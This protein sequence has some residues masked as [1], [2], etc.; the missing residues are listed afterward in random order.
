M[1]KSILLLSA[2]LAG[3]AFAAR[4]IARWDVVPYQRISGTFKAGVVAFHEKSVQVEFSVNGKK[5]YT[6][7]RPTL[8]TRTKVWEYVFAFDATKCRDG[9]VKIGATA[10]VDGE[11]PYQL[12]DLEMYANSKKTQGSRKC[13]WVDPKDGNEFAE[14]TKDAPVKSLKQAVAKAGDGG[15]VFL[16]PG[17]YQ[18]KMIGGGKDNKYWTLLMP[19]KGVKRSQVKI[20]GGRTGTD[21]LHFKNVEFFSEQ[22]DGYG[23]IIMGEGGETMGWFDNC[24]FYNKA[25]R[26]AGSVSVFG[27]KMRAFVTGGST[28]EVANGPQCELVRG[29][30]ISSVACDALPFDNTLVVN[31]TVSD[32]D[33]T[34]T[35]GDP[36]LFNGFAPGKSWVGDVILYNV[37]ATDVK[38]KGLSGRR[39]R[40]SAFVNVS[41]ESTGGT[42]VYSRFCEEIENC[43]FMQVS[44]VDQAVQLMKTKNGSI[45]FLPTDVRFYN[46]VMKGIDGF[47][48]GGGQKGLTVSNCAFYNIDEHG[49]QFTYGKKAVAINRAFADEGAKN[50]ALPSD[51]PALTAGRYLQT[52]PVDINGAAYPD[53][54]RPCGAYAK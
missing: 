2:V 3:A 50:F 27:N 22:T 54:E 43:L 7:E 23:A 20:Q 26:Y 32:I 47:G 41:V 48:V 15:T 10:I 40:D 18:A 42:L 30:E 4:P 49:D 44:L 35:P 21:K 16:Y 45:D 36:D 31:T 17:R 33:A 51:S 25:G 29:H 52:V 28:S 11:A 12:P 39:L 1:K 38:A 24:K 6:A 34:G 19:A 46:C 14:G 37:K 9:L 5:E 13:V 8:N 53:H